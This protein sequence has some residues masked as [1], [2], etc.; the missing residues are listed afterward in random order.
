MGLV[1][2]AQSHRR[3]LEA[4][5]VYMLFLR[6]G[7]TDFDSPLCIILEKEQNSK[8]KDGGKLA[9]CYNRV[10]RQCNAIDSPIRN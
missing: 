6:T 9:S 10:N 4:R 2:N 3:D 7:I 8:T 1:W 5:L